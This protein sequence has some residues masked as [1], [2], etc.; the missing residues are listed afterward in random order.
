MTKGA[1]NTKNLAVLAA[2][3]AAHQQHHAAPKDLPQDANPN[4]EPLRMISSS[5]STKTQNPIASLPISEPVKD[6]AVASTNVTSTSS[7]SSL[8]RKHEEMD[9][10]QAFIKEILPDIPLI[11]YGAGD[12]HPDKIDPASAELVAILAAQYVKKLT[13]AAVDA[14]DI[15]TDGNGG[16]LPPEPYQ[17]YK[18]K[19]VDPSNWDEEQT[20]P[21][22]RNQEIKAQ[23][24][25]EDDEDDSS[26]D[27]EQKPKECFVKGVDIYPNRIREPH[28]TIPS[29]IGLQS[30]VFPLCNDAEVYAKIMKMKQ[31]K[32]DIDEVLIDSSI[33]EFIKG[34]EIKGDDGEEEYQHLSDSVYRWV[35]SATE[36]AL[37]AGGT[38]AEVAEATAKA[39]ARDE[40]RRKEMAR[41]LVG[42]TKV[43]IGI[44]GLEEFLSP[45][46]TCLKWATE[47]ENIPQDVEKE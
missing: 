17:E 42:R 46:I 47:E 33:M 34:E 40:A 16:K 3:Q 21:R 26:N 38:I 32:K 20:K 37:S 7:N 1:H 15:L 35:N 6:I 9:P 5:N 31:A 25:A 24:A 36:S 27:L 43:S 14:H 8:K 23:S 13:A 28:S 10:E 18:K 41:K 39:N 22:I 29:T 11:M 44:P 19:Q 45:M 12:V 2:S 4:T 30:F